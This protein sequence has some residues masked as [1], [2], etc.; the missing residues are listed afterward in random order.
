MAKRHRHD[1]QA[2]SQRDADESDARLREGGSQDC[3]ATAA[4]NQPKRAEKLGADTLTQ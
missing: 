2:E 4:K 1:S 3:G